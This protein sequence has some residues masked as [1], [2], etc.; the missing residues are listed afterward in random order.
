MTNHVSLLGS[1]N[2]AMVSSVSVDS[3]E[4]FVCF[5]GV[6]TDSASVRGVVGSQ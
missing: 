2:V 4:T 1:V 5:R 3:A 6:L